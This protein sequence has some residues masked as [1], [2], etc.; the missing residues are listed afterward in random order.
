[1]GRQHEGRIKNDFLPFTEQLAYSRSRV[2]DPAR[3][4]YVFDPSLFSEKIPGDGSAYWVSGMKPRVAGGAAEIDVTTLARAD[5]MPAKQV[6]FGGLY[7]NTARGYLARMRGLLRVSVDEFN[8]LW[9]PE[10]WEVGW[11]PLTPLTITASDL[12]VPARA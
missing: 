3:V 11:Q 10:N 7:T 12:A 2:R 9:H 8:A 4:R 6:V 5:Q 1:I